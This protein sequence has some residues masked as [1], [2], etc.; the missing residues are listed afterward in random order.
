MR[1][2]AARRRC[3]SSDKDWLMCVASA[4]FGAD[5]VQDDGQVVHC[6]TAVRPGSGAGIQAAGLGAL[7][8]A[9]RIQPSAM[10]SSSRFAG[11]LDDGAG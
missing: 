6:G 5:G 10:R 3:A 8:D 7:P 4:A 11:D 9:L 2:K 1:W